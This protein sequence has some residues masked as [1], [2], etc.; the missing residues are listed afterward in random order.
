MLDVNRWLLKVSGIWSMLNKRNEWKYVVHTVAVII[1]CQFMFL[2]MEF[3][4]LITSYQN[5]KST[6]EQLGVVTMH[7]ISTLKTFNLYLKRNEISR[8][9]DDLHCND[10]TESSGATERKNIQ[11]K[12][13][14][15]VRRLCMF[16][17]YMGNGTSTILCATSLIHLVI[18]K[19]ETDYQEFCSTVQPIVISTPMHISSITH[20]S[21]FICAFQWM[22]MFLYGWQIVGK[23]I[24]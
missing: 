2:P 4:K 22:C 20:A 15:K 8:I 13:H 6:M 23:F 3:M 18:C 5:I 7:S 1:V 16:F 14:K 12:F 24:L 21:W 11:V 19:R 17:F 10:L 9:I